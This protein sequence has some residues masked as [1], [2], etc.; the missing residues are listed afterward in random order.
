MEKRTAPTCASA[1]KPGF[2]QQPL[3]YIIVLTLAG[4]NLNCQLQ[5]LS[6]GTKLTIEG[7]RATT[8]RSF[9]ELPQLAK[10]QNKGLPGSLN[11]NCCG[12]CTGFVGGPI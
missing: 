3:L 2:R 6:P 8:S 5:F 10:S 12:S 4:C 7:F 9:E 11:W 1:C